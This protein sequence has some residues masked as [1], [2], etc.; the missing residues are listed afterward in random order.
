LSCSI[1]KYGSSVLRGEG[2]I[3]RV[4]ADIAR[5]AL[6]SVKLIVVV[7][8]FEGRTAALIG[9]ARERAI[10]PEAPAYARLVSSG[11]FESAAI[12]CDALIKSGADA[13]IATPRR[14]GLIAGGARD[15]ASPLFLDRIA[16][17]AAFGDSPVLIV[18]GFSAIDNKGEPV[19]LGR[20]GSDLTAVHIAA[21]MDL[22]S[23]R[24][25]KDVVGVFDRDPNIH[26]NAQ[27]LQLIT[28]DEAIAIVGALIQPKA[29]IYAK[30]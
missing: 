12:L 26:A 17:I 4:A 18:P 11:E 13:R 10:A 28:H 29:L 30:K 15:A 8:A 25:V 9:M 24:L 20:G 27:L 21:S 3:P 2:D 19:L 14:I 1:V 6:N 22:K 5:Q 7:S 16:V 23:V